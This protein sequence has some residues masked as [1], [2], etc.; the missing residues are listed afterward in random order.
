MVVPW[1]FSMWGM[2]VIGPISPPKN[3]MGIVFG[4]GDDI[5]I[6]L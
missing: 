4:L 2:D 3:P 5:V 1:S 6:G